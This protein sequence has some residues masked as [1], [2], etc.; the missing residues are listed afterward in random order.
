MVSSYTTNKNIEKPSYN[1]YASDPTGWTQPINSDWDIIDAAF[2]GVQVKNPTGVS[3]TVALVASEYQKLILV[4]GTSATGTAT[5]TANITYTI[6]VGVGGN[7]IIYNNTTG[8]YT[9]TFAQASGGGT[10]VVLDQGSRTLVFSDGNNVNFVSALPFDNSI[11]T[12]MLQDDCVTT[13][14]IID[15]AVTY[16]KVEA[17]S[18][19]TGAEFQSNTAD[20]LLDTTGVWN[21]GALTALT[22]ASTVSVDLSTG[23]NF[24]LTLGGNRT[25]GNP[26]NTKVGQS[27][28]IV[29]T[30]PSTYTLG[31]G[32]NYKFANASAPTVTTS[33]TT[34]LSYFVVSSTYIV[35]SAMNG[36]A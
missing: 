32:S 11:T 1:Q 13:P 29:V 8:A 25:L 6:P 30:N 24:S 14:K 27:G 19:A 34:I 36:V 21:S 10:S 20:K 35:V 28:I 15:E 33:G 26:A 31:F 23:F 22:D 4:F 2:G 5:L 3:G 16:P 18:I 17:A 12:S 7:W 9:I